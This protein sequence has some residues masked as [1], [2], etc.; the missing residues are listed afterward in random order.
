[1]VTVRRSALFLAAALLAVSFPRDM[2]A[3]P[4]SPA[5]AK[6]LAEA[7]QALGGRESAA[8]IRTLKLKGTLRTLGRSESGTFEILCALP[9]RFIQIEQRAQLSA[10]HTVREPSSGPSVE[11]S[12]TRLG[13]NGGDLIFQPHVDRQSLR[14]NVLP[15]T[16]A[17]LQA[18]MKAARAGFANL[19]LGLFADSFAGLPLQFSEAVG[20]DSDTSVQVAGPGVT[21]TLAFNRQTRLPERFGRISYDDYRDVA[22]RKVPFRFTDGHNEWIVREFLVNVEIGD[23][24]FKPTSRS[25]RY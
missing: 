9:D 10:G 12:S 20:A 1:M 23:K 18:A 17:E 14:F 8:A 6:L 4:Q 7:R 16:R 11:R 21:G 25:S 22:G 19:T 15:M 5:V 2:A 3:V 13:F 24:V